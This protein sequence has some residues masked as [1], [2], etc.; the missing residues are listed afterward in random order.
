MLNTFEA[1]YDNGHLKWLNERP[2]KGRH[3]VLVTV[4]SADVTRQKQE[5]VQQVLKA[6]CGAW[7]QDK[8]L[9]ALDAEL[10]QQRSEWR[11][12]LDQRS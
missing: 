7:G 12:R 6:T 8:T 3:R 5:A 2:H 10:E 9:D 11:F 4:L 1:I